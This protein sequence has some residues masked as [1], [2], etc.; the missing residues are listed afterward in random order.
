[1]RQKEEEERKKLELERKE[2]E[3]EEA[4]RYQQEV[5]AILEKAQEAERRLSISNKRGRT[6][7]EIS[8]EE[9]EEE[10]MEG[11]VSS[12][13]SNDAESK[14]QSSIVNTAGENNSSDDKEINIFVS[15]SS[16]K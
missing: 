12:D 11:N 2:K 5:K 3:E 10:P 6:V 4:K 15:S 13:E 7:K 8:D 9:S 16:S 1:M 14:S